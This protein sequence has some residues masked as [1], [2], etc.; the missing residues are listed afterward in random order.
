MEPQRDGEVK[1]AEWKAAI[2]RLVTIAA[3]F[4]VAVGLTYVIPQAADLRPWIPGDPPPMKRLY[5][6]DWSKGISGTRSGV[7]ETALKGDLAKAALA[8]GL[9]ESLAA[10]LGSEV[11]ILQPGEES[12][13]GGSEPGEA[14]EK[15]PVLIDPVELEGLVRPIEDPSGKALDSFYQSLLETARDSKVTRI[16]HWGDSTIAADDV[17]GTLRRRFQG[18]FGDSGHGFMLVGK[19]T[20]PYRHR[21]VRTEQSGQ[22]KQHMVISGDRDDG[23]YGYG[24]VMFQTFGSGKAWYETMA[25]GPIGREVTDFEIFYQKFPRAGQIRL[26]VDSGDPVLIPASGG[27]SDAPED[28]FFHIEVPR[29]HHRFDLSFDG[30]GRVYG[31][32][33]END[34][35][36]VVYDS[37]GIVGARA[38]RLQNLDSEHMAAQI[39]RRDPDLLVI[40]FGGNESGDRK[41]NFEIYRDNLK[42]TVSL[43]RAGRPEASCL[44]LAPLDQG[45]TGP[46]GRVR[47]I[48]TIP[49]IVDVQRL[50]AQE[51]GCAFF[52]TFQAMGGKGAMARWHKSRP[53]LGWGDYRHATPAGYEVIGNM[54]Y[55]ALLSG[56]VEFLK[57]RDAGGMSED[58]PAPAVNDGAS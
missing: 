14:G 34:S 46:R 41:M 37:L 38:Q 35:P 40:A 49:R 3:V 54:I 7:T 26:A 58:V 15:K 31:V 53:R 1:T 29:G 45:E 13:E 44:L 48:P 23:R 47:T 51:T 4:A 19:G 6:F 25:E 11:G 10:N 52:D 17:T 30:E 22:W 24:G 9:G 50:V 43:L 2:R 56:F 32:V 8:E 27:T 20:M 12:S 57:A 18:R 5:T 55:K 36:G 42:K 33:L 39:S 28:G 16:A 21:D